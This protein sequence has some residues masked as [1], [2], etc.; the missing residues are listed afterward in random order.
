MDRALGPIQ[1]DAFTV[2]FLLQFE[3]ATVVGEAGISICERAGRDVQESGDA[4]NLVIAHAHE[5]LDAAA[6]AA[7]P[8]GGGLSSRMGRI[9]D[10]ALSFEDADAMIL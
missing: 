1:E 7:A 8:A 2:L 4:V 10:Y 9:H 6:F 3:A 5:P